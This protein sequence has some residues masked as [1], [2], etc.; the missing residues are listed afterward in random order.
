MFDNL[1][2]GIYIVKETNLPGYVDVSDVFGSPLDNIINVTLPSGGNVTGRNFVDKRLG[3]IS[4]NVMEDLDNDDV[5]DVDLAGVNITLLDGSGNVIASRL[6]DSDGN[7]VFSDLP[8]G[9]YSV[10]E[11]NLPGYLDVSDVEGNPLDNKILVV[12]SPGNNITGRDFVD[13]LPTLSPTPGP[14]YRPTPGPT[15][16]PTVSPTP[17][18]TA[19][20]TS[21]PTSDPTPGP[22]TRP[23]ANPTPDPTYRPTPSPTPEPTTKPT[24]LPTVV[25]T[26]SP[27]FKPTPVPC[28][29]EEVIVMED[30]EDKNLTGWQYGKTD[31]C[32]YFTNF[33]G[34]YG[35]GDRFPTKTYFGIPTDA[36]TVT[37]EFDFYEIDSWD[38]SESDSVLVNIDGVAVPIGIF[39]ARTDEGVRNGEKDGIEIESTSQ[40]A[41]AEQCFGVNGT[42]SFD[43]K[44][45]VKLTIPSIYF[46]DGSLSVTFET[47]VSSVS[48]DESA[49]FDNVKITVYKSCGLP[50][51]SPT[52]RPTAKPTPVPTPRPSVN[53]TPGPTLLPTPSPTAKPT[54]EPTN[55]PTANP[56]PGPTDRP[57]G[58][59]TATP[60]PGPTSRPTASPTALPTPGPTGRPTGSPTSLPTPGPTGRPTVSPT[61]TPTPGPTAS[62]TANPTP[63][64]TGRP[65]GSPTATPTFVPFASLTL[66]P[67]PSPTLF[68][69]RLTTHPSPGPSNRPS[70]RPIILPSPGPSPIPTSQPIYTL[71][72]KPTLMVTS[73]PT[74]FPTHFMTV[75]PTPVSSM[76]PSLIS[77]IPTPWPTPSPTPW[78]TSNPIPTPLPNPTIIPTIAP[79]YLIPSFTCAVPPGTTKYS[80]I[81]LGNAQISGHSV[82]LPV[83]VGGTLKDGTPNE[84]GNIASNTRGK[85]YVNAFYGNT[86][87]TF[88]NFP[89]GGY[90]IISNLSEANLQWDHFEWIARNARSS[91][92]QNYKVV[93]FTT[94]GTFNLYD[95]RDGGQSNDNGNT[96]M[97]FNTQADIFLTK[98]SDG[99]AF[100]PSVIAPFSRVT[101]FGDAQSIDGFVV[102]KEFTDSGGNAGQLQM[103]GK[104][105]TGPISCSRRLTVDTRT[106][107]AGPFLLSA[108]NNDL[109]NHIE[110]PIEVATARDCKEMSR[111]AD[112]VSVSIDKCAATPL[113]ESIAIIS[114]DNDSI[115]FSVSQS[116]TGGVGGGKL[117]WVATDFVSKDDKL[118]CLT[119]TDVKFGYVNTYTAQ[120]EDGTTVIDLFAFD[121]NHGI[122]KQTDGS[123][124]TVPGACNVAG[125]S[126]KICHFRYLLQCSPSLCK[127]EETKLHM[128]HLGTNSKMSR[129]HNS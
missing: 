3:S 77:L 114:Q 115:T 32:S 47:Y 65:T 74:A 12:L 27:T 75:K 125:D 120:C 26:A 18:P 113:E 29:R 56:T 98:T 58:V 88:N 48:A 62:P 44:H 102:A 7:Y 99:R 11:K 57:T 100:G 9:T 33:L 2:T 104:G 54:S 36:S 31:S 17:G 34:R 40:G 55:R 61:A 16:R 87:Q 69:F 38:G 123:K 78:P 109:D 66:P 53:P 51:L 39:D 119:E 5:G 79:F 97:I 20:P 80:L 73:V 67:S 23:T 68:P 43:Q 129:T 70:P 85:S 10:V 108:F 30:F 49:G 112:I 126:T 72:Y 124:V 13:R 86:A 105:Y 90:S 81:T 64:P 45:H 118:V 59:P 46:S 89:N 25:P 42:T 111:L 1:P 15:Y 95:A 96:L 92:S 117:S 82:Y 4:G 22:T 121:G 21:L 128:R 35:K 71:T 101:L 103:H 110:T 91:T 50:T 14:T 107:S 60:T 83:A 93:V 106:E 52:P 6:T 127:S 94:G 116:F 84:S 41:P 122:L 8:A 19:N 28:V 63:G 37:I 24:S 76:K